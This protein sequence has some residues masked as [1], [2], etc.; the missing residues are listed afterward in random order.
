MIGINGIFI[1]TMIA[2]L[3]TIYTADPIVLYKRIF[4][5]KAEEYYLSCIKSFAAIIIAFV[6]T[7]YLCSFITDI[8]Y[9]GF[10][11][12]ALISFCI[13]NVIYMIIYFRTREFRFYYMLM[14]RSVK[15]SYR[16]ILRY[17]KAKIR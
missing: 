12:K 15:P 14:R 7:N 5:K 10:I 3:T 13:P 1:G 8:G 17:L 6:V 2:Y 11:F 9:G 16:Y 4:N